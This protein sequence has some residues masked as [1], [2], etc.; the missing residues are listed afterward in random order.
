MGVLTKKKMKAPN[1]CS[2]NSILG[3]PKFIFGK[4]KFILGI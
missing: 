3:I 2:I 1:F 4:P